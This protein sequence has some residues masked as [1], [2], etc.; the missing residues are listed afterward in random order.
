MTIEANTEP[1]TQGLYDELSAVCRGSVILTGDSE[2]VHYSTSSSSLDWSI[3]NSFTNYISIFNG[4]VEAK[5]KAVV[6]PLDA[7]DVSQSESPFFSSQ[8]SA[9]HASAGYSRSAQGM[10]SLL[11]SKPAAMGPPVVL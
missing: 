7:Q 5:A 3:T 2:W 4:N 9:D 1:L 10:A 6:C 11:Q 8:Q